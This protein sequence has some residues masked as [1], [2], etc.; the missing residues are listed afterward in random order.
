MTRNPHLTQQQVDLRRKIRRLVLSLFLI[1]PVILITA[2]Y[3]TAEKSV[4]IKYHK[5]QVDIDMSTFEYKSTAISSFIRGAWYDSS[6]NYLILKL[7][8]TY[9]HF[10]RL[11]NKTWKAFKAA[12]SFGT[13]FNEKIKGKFDCIAGMAPNYDL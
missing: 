11:D 10:C 1:T 8:D 4:S 5:R 6:K 13:Y 12:G 7:K 2:E 9:Y 3:V